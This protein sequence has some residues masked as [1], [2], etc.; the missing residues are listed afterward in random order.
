MFD[1]DKFD[2]CKLKV[3]TKEIPVPELK[4]FFSEKEKTVFVIKTISGTEY[5]RINQEVT[6]NK[7]ELIRKI[8]TAI[9]DGGLK[10][11]AEAAKICLD[12]QEN[13][14]S[15]DLIYR[16]Y[17]VLYGLQEP[18]LDTDQIIKLRENFPETFYGL[19]K[20]ISKLS[21]MGNEIEGE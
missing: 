5:G 4:K 2:S 14:L 10:G 9:G 20:E 17:H 6:E 11:V 16:T 3:R 1:I 13:L 18:K 8:K 7:V 12:S 19:S 15:D 21:K